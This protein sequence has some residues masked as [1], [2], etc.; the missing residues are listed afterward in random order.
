[1]LAPERYQQILGRLEAQGVVRTIAL[2]K[3]LE[4]TD[5]TIRRDLQILETEGKLTRI[6]G[7]ASNQKNPFELRSFNERRNL[8]IGA[9]QAIAKAA[10]SIIQPQHTYAFD[11]STTALALIA[12][13][14]D[15]PYRVI[16]NAHAV[17]EELKNKEAIELVSTGGRYHHK[18]NTS[19]GGDSMQ[20]LRRHK[21]HAAFV[22]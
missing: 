14:P 15:Q 7:G 21:V 9:K 11:S 10:L 17:M 13:L 19:V 6:H 2:A 4:V 12:L 1:M 18:T 20:A 16:T 22:S 5:E 3:A 8:N